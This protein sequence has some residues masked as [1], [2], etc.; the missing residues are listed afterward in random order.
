MSESTLDPT[1]PAESPTKDATPLHTLLEIWENLLSNIEKSREERVGPQIAAR[2]LRA[3][4][5]LP[6]QRIPAYLDTYHSY[7]EQ[8]RDVLRELISDNPEALKN[9][10]SEDAELNHQLYLDLLFEW[11]C[12]ALGFDL[13]WDVTHEDSYLQLAA[14]ADAFNFVLGDQ[15][16]VAHFNSIGFRL[17]EE[18]NADLVSALKAWVEEQ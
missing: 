13:T 18:E 15:G 9:L 16:L 17:T 8:F 11:N 4:P 1:A 14:L 6:L 10:G 2:I 12:L 3:W 5:M 7:L